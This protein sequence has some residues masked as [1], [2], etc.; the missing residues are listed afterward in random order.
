MLNFFALCIISKPTIL[1]PKFE[2]PPARL[3]RRS[4]GAL[5]KGVVL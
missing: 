5:A 3:L 4:Y 1:N 2:Y